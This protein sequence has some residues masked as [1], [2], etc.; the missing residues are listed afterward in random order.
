MVVVGVAAAG[1]I[2]EWFWEF[3][4]WTL[5]VRVSEM[6]PPVSSRR[7]GGPEVSWNG[8]YKFLDKHLCLIFIYF[9]TSTYVLVYVLFDQSFLFIFYF[10]NIAHVHFLVP[11]SK[12]FVFHP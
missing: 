2:G 8:G 5:L 1:R 7:R 12:S 3:E 9:L 11:N 4:L 10:L 6:L